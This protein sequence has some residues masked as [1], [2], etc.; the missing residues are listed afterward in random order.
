MSTPNVT[1]T[2]EALDDNKVKLHVE[3]DEATFEVALDAAFKKLAREVRMPGFRPG[4]VPR[5]VLEARVGVEYAR[6]EAIQEAMGS[7]Y[8]AALKNH[9]V[10]AIAQP[11]IDLES[12]EESG[13]IVFDATV[14]VRPVI[15]LSG[16]D[17]L[18]VAIPNPVVSSEAVDDQIDAI[19]GRSAELV[20][21]ERPAQ[22]GDLVTID[23]AGTVDGEPLPGLVADDY[24][25]EVGSGAVGP[26]LD[27]ELIGATA[28]DELDFTSEHP[29][30][31]GTTID[32]HVVVHA[33]KE[34]VLP[35][36][37]DEWVDENT[38]FDTVAE[39]R[40]DIEHRLGEAAL[41]RARQ[42]LREN[43]AAKLGEMVEGDIPES[44]I[45]AEMN[46]QLQN[47]SYSLQ[48][49]G[50]SLQQWLM[51]NGKTEAEFAEDLKD[52]SEH[53]ARV[54]LALR[55]IAA[56]E[57]L[58]PSDDDIDDEVARLAVQVGDKPA[59]VRARLMDNDN[60]LSLR[61]DLK[62]RAALEWLIERVAIVDEDSG[63]AIERSL[64]EEPDDGP[65][66]SD[67]VEA[68]GA[69]DTPEVDE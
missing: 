27:E 30:Q 8:A 44:L 37:T 67:E 43:T 39:M 21:V 24:S 68:A 14:E 15:E 62:K 25:Y 22:D 9:D 7:Y 5:K 11:D 42:A 49:Q 66:G 10:D 36:L 13:P 2:V 1:S 57:G 20:E 64:L 38:E 60:L 41:R 17:A 45:S 58:A 59:S 23:I 53:S 40:A 28:D 3:V 33:V 61:D 55:A 47:V 56:A 51:F 29:V 32:F 63:E 52:G 54:D 4:K 46:E 6:A 69:D 31:V 26:E 18:E 48:M 16:Y 35:E 34:R 50:I 12:G 19:R 65:T